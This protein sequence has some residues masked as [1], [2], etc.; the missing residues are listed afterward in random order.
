MFAFLEDIY[1][2]TEPNRVGALYAT[3]QEA[4]WAHARIAIHLGKTKV[5][6]SSGVRPEICTV[7]ER[8]ARDTDRSARVWRGSEIPEDQ[9]GMKILGTPLGN[10]EFVRRSWHS[11]LRNTACCSKRI[12]LLDDVQSAWLLLA[13]CAAARANY[14]LRCVEPQEV[15]PFAR[16]HDS[17]MRQC[18]SQILQV[19]LAEVDQATQD[20][21][22]VPLSLGGLGVR[23]AVRTS[24]AAYWASWADCLAMINE[25]HPQVADLL[26][27]ELEGL[28]RTSCLAAAAS[29]ARELTGVRDFDPPSWHA[30]AQGAR[31]ASR[32]PEELEPGCTR[33]GW[34]HEAASRVE[35]H[36]RDS[37]LFAR[38]G[39]ARTAL[40]RSQGGPRA[41]LALSACPTSRLTKITPQLFRVVLLRRLGLPLPLTALLPVWPST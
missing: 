15:E 18:L 19:N 8:M 7:L 13:H 22:T 34:Q 30:L 39:T 16:A 10:P 1:F 35:L 12:P 36:F 33:D 3:L 4:L 37:D 17:D 14:S 9:Q 11:S 5:W 41:G 25:R 38:I 20:T 29:A 6:N 26:V 40:F 32:E 31:P 23:S 28:P 2:I 21:V 24:K 27:E